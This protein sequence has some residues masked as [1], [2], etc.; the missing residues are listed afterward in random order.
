MFVPICVIG[1]VADNE[2]TVILFKAFIVVA[3][4]PLFADNNPD[5]LIVVAD[6]PPFADITP[7]IFAP[8]IISRGT[9]GAELP[10]PIRAVPPPIKYKLLAIFALLPNCAMGIVAVA[11]SAKIIPFAFIEEAVS[12]LFAVI[13]CEAS[14]VVVIKPPTVFIV[15][16]VSIVVPVIAAVAFIV[17]T[18]NPPFALTIPAEV[19][20]EAFKP[21]SAFINP[22]ATIVVVVNPPFAFT[23]PK[24]SSDVADIPLLAVINPEAFI[25]VAS[26]PPFAIICFPVGTVIP[27]FAV[28]KPP[29][30][31]VLE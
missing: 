27:P 10:I 21:A 22:D 16:L 6:I 12:P 23:N 8:P 25:V 24:V 11:L 2:D 14:I 17:V 4:I 20:V 31:I 19:I 13:N 1:V 28:I 18:D 3:D 29:A 9:L 7:D 26:M 30:I 15:L 5:A